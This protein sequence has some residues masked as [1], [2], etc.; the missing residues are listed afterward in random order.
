MSQRVGTQVGSSWKA[1][2][3]H[4][5]IDLFKRIGL[6]LHSP[7]LCSSSSYCICDYFRMSGTVICFLEPREKNRLHVHKLLYAHMLVCF[8]QR[9]GPWQLSTNILPHCGHVPRASIIL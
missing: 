4:F 7:R 8:D 2:N 5:D 1:M 9:T 3:S 6:L